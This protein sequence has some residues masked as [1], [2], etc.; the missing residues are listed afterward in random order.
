[1]QKEYVKA[2]AIHLHSTKQLDSSGGLLGHM[3]QTIDS[4]RKLTRHTQKIK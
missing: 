4:L 3:D 1:M 2:V